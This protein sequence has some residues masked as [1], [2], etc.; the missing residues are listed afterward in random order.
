MLWLRVQKITNDCQRPDNPL[1][2]CRAVDDSSWCSDS[3]L[4]EERPPC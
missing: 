2:D 3:L 1:R 4:C